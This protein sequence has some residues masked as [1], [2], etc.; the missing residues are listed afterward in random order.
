[1]PLQALGRISIPGK[2]SD[3]GESSKGEQPIKKKLRSASSGAGSNVDVVS[4][5][6]ED[7]EKTL[8]PRAAVNNDTVTPRFSKTKKGHYF[9]L[10]NRGRINL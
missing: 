7:S 9:F 5:Q 10:T 3:A 8:S 6:E 1:M 4:P 2:N